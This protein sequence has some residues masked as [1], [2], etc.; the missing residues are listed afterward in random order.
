LNKNLKEIET[1]L[2]KHDPNFTEDS[3]REAQTDWTKSIL[4]SFL[5]GPYPYDSESQKETNQI[6]LN[7]ECVRVPEVVFQPT[8]AGLD[9]AGIVEIAANILTERLA[10][11]AHRDSVLKDIFLTGGNTMFQGFD[12]RLRAELRAVLPAEQRIQVRRAQDCVLDAW[13]GAAQ[14]AG[15]ETSRQGFITRAEWAEKGGEYIKEHSLGNAGY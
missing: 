13:R 7:V 4:H 8:I 14:W 12:E 5:H 9:Q 2:L 11:S 15:S 10:D 1:Q 6:H 3:T